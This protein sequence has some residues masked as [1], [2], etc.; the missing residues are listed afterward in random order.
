MHNPDYPALIKQ[1]IFVLDYDAYKT[2]SLSTEEVNHLIPSL[3]T[4]ISELFEKSI[5]DKLRGVM[6]EE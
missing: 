1:K 3:H 5:G 2:G 6:N 4:K